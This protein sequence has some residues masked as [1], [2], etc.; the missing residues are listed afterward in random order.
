MTEVTIQVMVFWDVMLCA[1][2]DSYQHLEEPAASNFMI[3]SSA[4]KTEI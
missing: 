1:L 4:I 3:T 2:I